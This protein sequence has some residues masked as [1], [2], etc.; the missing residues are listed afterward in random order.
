MVLA[1]VQEQPEPTVKKTRKS[2]YAISSHRKGH[3]KISTT[4]RVHITFK[5]YVVH[6]S[7][8]LYT[9][10]VS[11]SSSSS[12]SLLS[13]SSSVTSALAS[14]MSSLRGLLSVTLVTKGCYVDGEGHKTTSK[15]I[16][17]FFLSQTSGW[18]ITHQ[19]RKWLSYYLTLY[20][21]FGLYCKVHSKIT[22]G[23]E[24]NRAVHL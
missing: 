23:T 17:N 2:H 18:I 6:S 12:S 14:A 22:V 15:S 24:W 8:K 11:G 9:T 5:K 16:R 13:S 1:C 21:F 7:T 19:R 10:G 3:S 20:T 4:I